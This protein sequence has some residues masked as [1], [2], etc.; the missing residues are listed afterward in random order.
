MLLFL[1]NACMMLK[2]NLQY[3]QSSPSQ[4]LTE[5]EQEHSRLLDGRARLLTCVLVGVSICVCVHYVHV[6]GV[7]L[8]VCG[9]EQAC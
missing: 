2:Q 1:D 9:H 8:R 4:I 6:C 7:Y 5:W 3:R